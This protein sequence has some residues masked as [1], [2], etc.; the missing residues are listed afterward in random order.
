LGIVLCSIEKNMLNKI[1]RIYWNITWECDDIIEENYELTP[2]IDCI[3]YYVSGFNAKKK[4]KQIDCSTCKTAFIQLANSAPEAELINL[5]SRKR[6]IHPN[7]AICPFSKKLN[8]ILEKLRC[9]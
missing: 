4:I 6:L 1:R 2:V 7:H 9:L 3:I 8:I 5:K